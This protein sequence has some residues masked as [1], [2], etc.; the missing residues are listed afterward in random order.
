MTKLLSIICFHL[1][2]FDFFSQEISYT[3]VKELNSIGTN[4]V[5]RTYQDNNGYIWYCTDMGLCKYDGQKVVQYTTADGLKSNFVMH[6]DYNESL[7]TGLISTHKGGLSLLQEGQILNYSP[8][9]GKISDQIG[10]AI[11]LGNDILVHEI[12]GKK[13]KLIKNDTVQLSPIYSIDTS[14]VVNDFELI[15]DTIYLATNQGI[16]VRSVFSNSYAHYNKDLTDFEFYSLCR[17]QDKIYACTN[18]GYIVT[19]QSKFELNK[20]E[21]DIAYTRIIVYDNYIYLHAYPYYT[22]QISINK[23]SQ[24]KIL[25]DIGINHLFVDYQNT[26]W[27]STNQLSAIFLRASDLYQV[28]SLPHQIIA[29]EQLNNQT[30]LFNT[31]DQIEALNSANGSHQVIY[32]SEEQT[33]HGPV[34]ML[35]IDTNRVL[36]KTSNSIFTAFLK[37]NTLIKDQDI[38]SHTHTDVFKAILFEGNGNL[39]VGTE[40]GL[41]IIDFDSCDCLY[42]PENH[43][44]SYFKDVPIYELKRHNGDV[45]ISTKK[46]VFVNQNQSFRKILSTETHISHVKKI[47]EGNTKGSLVFLT[48]KT[49]YEYDTKSGNIREIKITNDNVQI[50]DIINVSSSILVATNKGVFVV[51]KDGKTIHSLSDKNGLINGNVMSLALQENDATL[52][53][54]HNDGI[55]L[56]K[57]D[58]ILANKQ[59]KDY[60]FKINLAKVIVNDKL[61]ELHSKNVFDLQSATLELQIDALDFI[62]KSSVKIS[63]ELFCNNLLYLDKDSA[64]PSQIS[65]MNLPNGKYSLRVQGFNEFGRSNVMLFDFFVPKRF[66]QKWWFILSSATF[67]IALIL[68]IILIFVRRNKRKQILE[69]E[70]Y[71]RQLELEHKAL[72]ALMNPHFIFNGLSSIQYFVRIA[73]TEASLEFIGN[74]SKLIRRHFETAQR[75]YISIDQEIENIKIFIDLES[76]RIERD[77][78]LTV[79]YSPENE[80]SRHELIPTF[81][82]QPIVENSIWH[83][84]NDSIDSPSVN[85]SIDTS[86]QDDIE[87]RIEDNGIGI[88]E[89]HLNKNTY[90]SLNLIKTRLELLSNKKSGLSLEFINR[91]KVTPGIPGTLVILRFPKIH[92]Q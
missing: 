10:K 72:V 75:S 29:F 53:L 13:L 40:S 22:L 32:V 51:T 35:K 50:N 92:I 61:V 3:K 73:D 7:K 87:I 63:Y 27:L 38:Y 79:S 34:N 12:R 26:L 19:T 2:V 52:I 69:N 89:N 68:L 82:L 49:L 8:K 71:T 21:E 80:T 88:T 41:R 16:Y 64:E 57:Y 37:G 54:G 43:L 76:T 86:S 78:A 9:V 33:Y 36:I 47:I 65:I 18:G 6:F 81:I 20:L 85:I 74:F 39:L 56:T 14:I 5:Y 84:F 48:A 62:D 67:I 1:L 42:K 17:Y 25:N 70:I 28:T 91:S 77:I 45:Y 58:E 46:G 23:K 24:K 66:Y 31:H 11:Y 59:A 15:N 44:L 60:N 55:T 83:G 4:I 30:T 90:S